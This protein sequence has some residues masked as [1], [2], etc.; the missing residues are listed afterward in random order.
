MK[1][2][3]YKDYAKTL[4]FGSTLEDKL[5]PP[6]NIVF[7]EFT[8]IEIPS[9]PGRIPRLSFSEKKIKFPKAE[10]FVNDEKKAMALHFFANHELLA[11][12]MMA[13][14][15]LKFPHTNLQDEKFKRGI[16]TTI[17]D[18]QRHFK[19]YLNRMKDFG[20]EFGDLPLN[21]FFWKQMPLLKTKEQ[22][23]A[24]MSLTF[25][26]A[27]LDFMKYYQEI[28]QGVGDIKSAEILKIIGEEEIS[29]VA[30]GVTHLNWTRGDQ[31]LWDYYLSLLPEKMSAARSKGPILNLEAR[32]K[33]GID[34]EFLNSAKNYTDNFPV[35]ERKHW[36][37]T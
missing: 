34:D 26:M 17:Q 5:L 8:E 19:M 28:Y 29:H 6:E 15:L 24:L 31:P 22:Y 14:S 12:E 4:L 21:D 32:E 1:A 7:E 37:R 30:F 11:I 25:E 33:T 10:A 18:E 13:A 35:T 3:S 27:N 20:L 9:V 16:L 23:L 36:K 2:L